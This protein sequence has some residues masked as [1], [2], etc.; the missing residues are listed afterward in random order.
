LF[1]DRWKP[2]TRAGPPGPPRAGDAGSGDDRQRVYSRHSNG[3]EQFFEYIRGEAGLS[4]LDLSGASQA[5]IGFITNLGHRL[6][7]ED[8]LQSLDFTFGKEP[9][10]Y[11]NQNV[12]HR[13]DAFLEQTLNFPEAHF[14]GALVWDGLEFLAS[15]LLKAFVERLHF[16]VRPKS[17]LLAVFHAQERVETIPAY[18]YRIA[19]SGTLTLPLRGLRRPAQFFN[20][21]AVEKLFQ[22]FE[23]VKFFLTRDNLR[24]VI[25]KR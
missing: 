21:R 22:P 6:Y 9:E 20:N 25:V 7:S 24:E 8:L 18:S 1:N 2:L 17:Y 13:I 12:Q 4:L 15:P 5:N 3:L 14:D 19:G 10:F 23:S 11:E 16:I